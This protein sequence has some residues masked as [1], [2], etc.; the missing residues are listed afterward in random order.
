MFIEF[1]GTWNS[2]K[3]TILLH[4]ALIMLIMSRHGL[5]N[6]HVEML[7][8]LYHCKTRSNLVNLLLIP[9]LRLFLFYFIM[10]LRCGVVRIRYIRDRKNHGTKLEY[11]GTGEKPSV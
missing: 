8:L 2:G 11:I 10:Q 7:R 3:L 1:D 6:K 9:P 5:A 4:E